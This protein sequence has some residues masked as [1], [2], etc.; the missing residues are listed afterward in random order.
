MLEELCVGSAVTQTS[1]VLLLPS[2]VVQIDYFILVVAAQVPS[3]VLMVDRG[4]RA[5][6]AGLIVALKESLRV[7]AAGLVLPARSDKVVL[8][9]RLV[10]PIR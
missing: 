7:I 1:T 6:I 2:K 8:E 9:Q 10:F 5:Q 4:V 3:R